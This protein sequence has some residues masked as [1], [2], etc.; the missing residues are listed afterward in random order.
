MVVQRDNEISQRL[1]P[2]TSPLIV[3]SAKPPATH[4]VDAVGDTGAGRMITSRSIL[5]QK[6]FSKKSIDEVAGPPSKSENFITGNG[7]VAGQ[8]SIGV[9][10][11]VFG[12]TECYLLPDCDL[13]LSSIGQTVNEPRRPFIWIPGEKPFII[14]DASKLKF[15]CPHKYRIYASY[16]DGNVPVWVD[17]ISLFDYGIGQSA[18]GSVNPLAAAGYADDATDNGCPEVLDDIPEDVGVPPDV[19]T[20]EIAR[21]DGATGDDSPGVPEP[22]AILTVPDV[23][24]EDL[25]IPCQ[26][27]DKTIVYRSMSKEALLAEAKSPEH[28]LNHHPHNPLC[29]IC[30][31]ANMRQKRYHRTTEKDDDQLAGVSEARTQLSSDF[32]VIARS[33]TDVNASVSGLSLIHI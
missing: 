19:G 31:E 17:D 11:K 24:V 33:L 4:S 32:I 1:F 3:A 29:E 23:N 14:T 5:Q 15:T 30:C 25:G 20:G 8:E 26:D 13:F 2:R 18:G 16:V 10:S 9:N 27:D 6:G 12:K 7:L 28:L 22:P 21:G